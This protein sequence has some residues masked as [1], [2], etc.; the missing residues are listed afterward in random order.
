VLTNDRIARHF[1][2][3]PLVGGLT[4]YAPPICIGTALEVL[5]TYEDEHLVE[6]AARLGEVVSER[7][8]QLAARY[9]VVGDTRGRGLL[10]VIELSESGSN[11]PLV[12]FNATAAQSSILAPLERVLADRGLYITIKWNYIILAPP[13]NISQKDLE[14]GLDIID[15][16]LQALQASLQPT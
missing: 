11:L 14:R 12:P 8:Q 5:R 6:H 7:L 2:E 9:S 10:Q 3:H 1:D 13:L 16:G 4:S 15:E